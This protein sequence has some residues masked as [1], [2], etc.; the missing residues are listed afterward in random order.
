MK[1]QSQSADA[2]ESWETFSFRKLLSP[3]KLKGLQK[4]VCPSE[5]K[6]IFFSRE[7]I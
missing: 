7:S 4:S 6:T 2:P 3:R 1:G 5:C